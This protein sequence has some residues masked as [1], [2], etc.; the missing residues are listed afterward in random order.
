MELISSDQTFQIKVAVISSGVLVG[1]IAAGRGR[2]F[3]KY[4]IKCVH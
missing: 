4:G 2:K 3:I 1:A